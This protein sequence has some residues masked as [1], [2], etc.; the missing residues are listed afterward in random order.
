MREDADSFWG[1]AIHRNTH[2][3]QYVMLLNRTK[4]KPKW[5]QEGIYVTFSDD[6][7]DPRG[8]SPPTKILDKGKWYPQVIGIDATKRETDKLAGRIA[9][10]FMHGESRWEI[11][12]LRPGD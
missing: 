12:F 2:L 6:L 3:S 4:D 8:W 9:R 10:F 5:P 11:V 7:K 1:P